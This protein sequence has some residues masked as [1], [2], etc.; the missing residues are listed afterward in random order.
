MG[1]RTK[2]F[3]IVAILG[4]LAGIIAQLTSEYIIPT[5]IDLLPA[6][7]NAKYVLSGLAG[8]LLTVFLVSIWAY[9]TSSSE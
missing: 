6:F 4:F 7:F 9:L 3:G 5:L 2:V 1:E 8:A